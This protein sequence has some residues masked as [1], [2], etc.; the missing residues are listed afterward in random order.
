MAR[1]DHAVDATQTSRVVDHSA[2]EQL[3]KVSQ[4]SY[5][6]ETVASCFGLDCY[7]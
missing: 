2:C 5:Q 7:L 3:S 1:V 6:Y 4:F